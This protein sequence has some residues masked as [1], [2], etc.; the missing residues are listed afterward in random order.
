MTRSMTALPS[1]HGRGRRK[2]DLMP[3]IPWNR[4]S[5]ASSRS[6]SPVSCAPPGTG[7]AQRAVSMSR[8]DLLAQPRRRVLPPAPPPSGNNTA[9]S[10]SMGANGTKSML[11]LAGPPSG[12][13]DM[14]KSMVLLGSGLQARA[15]VGPG[16]GAGRLRQA[17]S[18]SQ[19]AV[20]TPRPTRTSM[21]RVSRTTGAPGRSPLGDAC[22]CRL[23]T[24]GKWQ[25]V[26]SQ[27]PGHGCPEAGGLSHILTFESVATTFLFSCGSAGRQKYVGF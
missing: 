26:C 1:Q 17:R 4:G 27:M 13:V 2:T 24:L 5:S 19:L 16:G 22:R 11:N 23:P 25:S 18:M 9:A 21:L 6:R 12:R 20:L 8:L 15:P 14:S 3:V 7:V 10:P